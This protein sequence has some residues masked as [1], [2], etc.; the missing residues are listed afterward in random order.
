[1]VL[2]M[3]NTQ[4]HWR[5]ALSK[6]PNS[7][8]VSPSPHLKTEAHTVSEMFSSYLEFRTMDTVHK[9]SH[10]EQGVMFKDLHCTGLWHSETAVFYCICSRLH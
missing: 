7:V 4:N 10:S 9:P 1:M 3:Y 6:G 8:C 5:L 2:M